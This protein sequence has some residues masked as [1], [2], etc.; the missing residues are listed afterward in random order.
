M[1]G[2]DLE[3][4]RRACERY[5]HTPVSILNFIEGTRF[6]PEKHARQGSPY[7]HLLKPKAGGFAFTLAAMDGRIREILDVTI[8]YP[9]R[10]LTFWDYLCGRVEKIM[11][12][13]RKIPVPEQFLE[14]DYENDRDFRDA[15]QSWVSRLWRGKDDLIAEH[16]APVPDRE[17]P[18]ITL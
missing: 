15:F 6:T 2:K 14:G 11:V 8:I 1:R 4:T 13:V 3:T 9:H 12:R 7:R 18:S 16:V 5:R 10:E 17:S